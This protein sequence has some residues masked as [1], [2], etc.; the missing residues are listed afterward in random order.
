MIPH[1]TTVP[2]IRFNHVSY[3]NFGV[4][5]DVLSFAHPDLFEAY[6]GNPDSHANSITA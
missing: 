2:Q 1:S 6:D 4:A 5:L 3:A